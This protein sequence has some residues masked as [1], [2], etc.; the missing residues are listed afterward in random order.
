MDESFALVGDIG[1]TNARFALVR[2]GTVWPERIRV[3]PG[4]EHPNLDSAVRAYLQEVGVCS[5]SDACVAFAGPT[6]GDQV[7]LTNSHWSFS[8]ARMKEVLGLNSLK[9]INDF[10][11]MALGIPHVSAEHLIR[12]GGGE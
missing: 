3:L 7:S 5:V 12:V 2:P 8:K 10:T 11:A 9:V 4:Q 1:G 6:Y